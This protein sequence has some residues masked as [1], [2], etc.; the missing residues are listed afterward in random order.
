MTIVPSSSPGVNLQA[1]V[2]V[3]VRFVE[4]LEEAQEAD[5]VPSSCHDDDLQQTFQPGA[6]GRQ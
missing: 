2:E 3:R 4:P 5:F 1:G 6:K